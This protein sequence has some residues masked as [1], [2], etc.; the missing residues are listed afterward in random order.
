MRLLPA[1]S[2]ELCA[3]R[4]ARVAMSS[5]PVDMSSHVETRAIHLSVAGRVNDGRGGVPPPILCTEQQGV[6]MG[7]NMQRPWAWGHTVASHRHAIWCTQ[8]VWI[9][10]WL[11]PIEST[12]WCVAAVVRPNDH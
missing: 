9:K 11:R 10:L 7:K 3:L 8:S 4:C 5:L 2:G 12:L 6:A 1:P